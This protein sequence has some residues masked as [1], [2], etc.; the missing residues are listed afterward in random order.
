[1]TTSTKTITIHAYTDTPDSC[2]RSLKDWGCTIVSRSAHKI[3]A[4]LTMPASDVPSES[5]MLDSLSESAGC[6][7]SRTRVV[8]D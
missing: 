5:D 2:C 4:T 1:M 6:I 3:V 8:V 7:R